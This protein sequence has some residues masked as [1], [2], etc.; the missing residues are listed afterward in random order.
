M[1]KLLRCK[2]CNFVTKEEKLGEV[3]P[4]CGVP[5]S[6]FEEFT[7]LVS[8]KRRKLMQLDLHPIT[9]HFPLGFILFIL[10]LTLI[11]LIFPNFYQTEIY[12]TIK[13]LSFTLPFAVI[14][15][16]LTGIFDANTRFKKIT[17]PRLKKK[18]IFGS[19]FLV[20]SIV[21]LFITYFLP[22]S[23]ALLILILILS[24]IGE[25]FGGINGYLGSSLMCTNVPN[26]S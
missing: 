11:N 7:P 19:G 8:K 21:L 16:M 15:G 25:V 22:P 6:A 23:T 18:I 2:Y 10:I 20:D 14:L 4:A 9:L 5:R 17:T 1:S 26:G 12:A 3:C 24:F 13:V